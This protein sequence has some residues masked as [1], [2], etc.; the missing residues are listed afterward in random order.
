MKD[1]KELLIQVT[2]Q[3]DSDGIIYEIRRYVKD[4]LEEDDGGC[5]GY[6]SGFLEIAHEFYGGNLDEAYEFTVIK[7][8]YQE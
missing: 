6:E 3:R 8:E 7:T 4:W 1:A 5:H 2:Y